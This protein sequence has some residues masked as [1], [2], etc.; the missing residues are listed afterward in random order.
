MITA[1]EI[2]NFKGTRDRVRIELK[3]ITLLFGPNSGGKS[4]ILHAI[5]YAQEVFDR[6]N[7]DVEQPQSGRELIDF[8]GFRN[9]LHAR[10]LSRTVCLRFES[11]VARDDWDLP[12]VTAVGPD[13]ARVHLSDEDIPDLGAQVSY[14]RC[15]TF[16]SRRTRPC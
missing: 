15:C 4:T 7:L 10:D 3:P 6:H 14:S 9:L 13:F 1:I 2:E 16:G 12:P 8:G 11:N 5:Q